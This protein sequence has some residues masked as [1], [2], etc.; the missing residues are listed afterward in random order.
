MTGLLLRLAGPLQS[1]GEHSAFGVRDTARFPT[2]SGII[3]LLACAQGLPRDQSLDRYTELEITVRIDR[4]GVILED[5]HTVGG[6]Y[7]RHLTVPTA[8]GKRRP[9]QQATIVSRR[10][11]LSDAAFVVAVTGGSELINALAAALE[12]PVWQP[13]LGRRS[14]PPEQPLLLALT[15]DPVAALHEAVPLARPKPRDQETVE[16]EFVSERDTADAAT[17]TVL[18]DVP[19]SFQRRQRSHH[20]RAVHTAYRHLPASLCAGYGRNYLDALTEYRK[21]TQQ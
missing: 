19:V 18:A 17:T 8:E 4:Q 20:T 16:V 5:F 15:A 6:G 1:W 21:E 12:R 11:Y 7:P 9:P 14:C 3:G 13:F 10:H 2:R